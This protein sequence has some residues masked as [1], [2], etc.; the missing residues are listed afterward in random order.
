M[1]TLL[2]IVLLVLGVQLSVGQVSDRKEIVAALKQKVSNGEPLVVHAFV[3][4]CDNI[5]QGIVP[6]TASLGNGMSLR[7]N[8]YWATSKGIK[9]Y[10]N[11]RD[12]WELLESIKDPS[13][14]VLERIVCVK[15]FASGQEVILIADAYRGDRMA[16]C[17]THY[18]EALAGKREERITY[19]GKDL[20]IGSEADLLAF[21]GHNGLMDE[22][23]EIPTADDHAPKDAVAIACY[24]QSWFNPEMKKVGG[25]PLVMATHLLFPGAMVLA[26][27]IDAWA[28]FQG[29]AAIDEA[30]AQAYHDM[31]PKVS[32]KSAR[33]LFATG[34]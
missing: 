32:M 27:I 34:Y 7:S 3:P 31:K 21:N 2:S 15:R 10:F 13:D 30:A 1:R 5:N 29:D 33:N 16:E 11:E 4:L 14:D 12:D 8:L 25:Y 28:T 6:T 20:S 24:A 22:T 23:I 19:Q 26:Y 9:R 18:F 17:L